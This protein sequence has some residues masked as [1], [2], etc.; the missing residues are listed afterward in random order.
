ME[1][2][3]RK[4]RIC[5]ARSMYC[6]YS[7]YLEVPYCGYCLYSPVFRFGTAGTYLPGVPYCGYCLYTLSSWAFSVRNIFAA[8]T[9]ILLL[10]VLG[11]RFF[12]RHLSYPWYCCTRYE[13]SVKTIFYLE[14]YYMLM[15]KRSINKKFEF[16]R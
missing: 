9:P 14:T 4:S 2:T 12:L 10:I 16:Q 11:L 3:G 15:G 7:Q 5:T 13:I 1:H 8:S 6:E